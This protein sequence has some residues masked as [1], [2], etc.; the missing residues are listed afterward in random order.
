MAVITKPYA[1]SMQVGVLVPN[2]LKGGD[3]FDYVETFPKKGQVETVLHWISNQIDNQFAQAG[4]IMPFQ[5]IDEESWP[6]HQTFYLEMITALGTAAYVGQWILNP[7]PA[8]NTGRNVNT[9]NVYQNMFNEELKK[10]YNPAN[11]FGTRSIIRFRAKT[12]SGTEA[13]YSVR[14]PVGP[15]LDYMVGKMNP[16]DALSFLYYTDLKHNL[17]MSVELEYGYMN[18]INWSDFFGLYKT[19]LAGISYDSI[20]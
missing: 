15:S 3:D 14:E 7:A 19:K 2:L 12:Y 10:I 5:V 18:P 16:E 9:G 17:Q 4:Y 6:D 8:L 1:N 11:P 20:D 13:E